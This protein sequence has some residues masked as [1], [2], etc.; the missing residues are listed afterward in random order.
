LYY[1]TA[2]HNLLH[3]RE[4]QQVLGA[5]SSHGIPV[6]LL[7]G[8]LLAETL[9]PTIG[10]RPMAD[11]DL[12]VP[13]DHVPEARS[14]L[15]G[16]GYAPEPGLITPWGA[17]DQLSRHIGMF[18][19]PMADGGATVDL[20]WHLVHGYWF[21]KASGISMEEVWDSVQPVTVAGQ[22]ALQLAPE[23]LLIHLCLHQV[24]KHL[25]VDLKD[26]LDIDL[27]IRSGFL[28]DWDAF[29]RQAATW[30]LR[31]VCYHA[32]RFTQTL[33]G[34]PIPRSVFASLAPGWLRTRA[35]DWTVT[36]D[37]CLAS[38]VGEV[39]P[40]HGHILHMAMVDRLRDMARLFVGLLWPDKRWLL[41]RAQALGGDL[42]HPR[43]WH[44]GRL[45]RYA[46][47]LINQSPVK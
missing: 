26:Y 47:A 6:V 25:F 44:W 38:T 37:Q 40:W 41:H 8:A 28:S 33:F 13:H 31:S 27:I 21:E 18:Q 39:P 3:Y 14:V 32:L 36:P 2:A 43:L 11:L 7:K 17:V 15:E 12:L 4:L 22:A 45:V 23:H 42:R 29:I 1:A 19:K 34:T 20:H 9:Y 24:E 5:L 30:R 10:M 46:L 35:V 16:L